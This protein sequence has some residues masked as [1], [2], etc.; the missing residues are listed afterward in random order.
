M[1]DRVE[2]PAERQARILGLLQKTG[3]VSIGELCAEL[4]VSIATVRRD[5]RDLET[6][7]LLRRTH[8]G[9]VLLEPLFYEPFRHDPSFQDVVGSFIE[10][11]RRIAKAASEL[12]Q[13]GETVALSG[14]TT[15]TE[16]VRS[17]R[18]HT[19]ITVIT[20]TVNVAM[21]LSTRKDI[22][23]IVTGGTLRGNWFT[24]VGPLANAAARTLF[25]DVMFL[26]VNGIHATQGLTCLHP[27]EAEFLNAMV[28]HCKRKIVVADHSKL[29]VTAK[30]L[31]CPVSEINMLITDTGAS[32]KAIAPF[33][34]LGISVI[35]V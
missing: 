26:G 29:G 15:T 24:L 5:L 25:A 35:R 1:T 23:V 14:G 19:G 21:E 4:R 20:N 3:S 6:R 10:E 2:S 12:V 8:G 7:S 17:L 13:N 11:K 31:L 32:D 30:W 34:K 9:A 22:E 16:V 33:E 27:Q 28:Q 18:L